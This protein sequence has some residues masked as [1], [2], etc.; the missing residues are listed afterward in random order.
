[1]ASGKVAQCNRGGHRKVR[2]QSTPERVNTAR[3]DEGHFNFALKQVNALEELPASEIAF[4]FTD[5]PTVR[6]LHHEAYELSDGSAAAQAPMPF[7]QRPTSSGSLE[8]GQYFTFG[9]RQHREINVRREKQ[10][11]IERQYL[12]QK[13]ISGGESAVSGGKQPV[14]TPLEAERRYLLN[15]FY[16]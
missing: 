7:F 10:P 2:R 12:L 11:P 9:A 5:S 13:S 6:R 14:A 8:K 1:M 15:P 3:P 4:S 16:G